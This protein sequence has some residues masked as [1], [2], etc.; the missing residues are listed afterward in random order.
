MSMVINSASIQMDFKP[1]TDSGYRIVNLH[2]IEYLGGRLAT[3]EMELW[4]DSSDDALKLVTEQQT[5]TIRIK[6][7][8]EDGIEYEIPVFI[9]SRKFY[10]L[11]LNITFVCLSDIAFTE[12][13]VSTE[14]DNIDD[15]LKTLY[16]GKQDIRT[17]TDIA[18]DLK[19]YQCCET[20]YELCTKL[21]YSF[22]NETIFAYSWE[23]LV[24][25][26][27]CG[28]SNSKGEME[29]LEKPGMK[30]SALT[31][32]EFTTP[33]TLNYNKY[34][35]YPP[36]NPWEDTDNSTTQ[37][38]YTE[39]EFLNCRAMNSY[40][41]YSIQGTDY[42]QLHQNYNYNRNLMDAGMYS[43][44]MIS[45]KDFPGYKIGDVIEFRS[46]EQNTK[47]PFT[48][49]LVATNEIY[50]ATEASNTLSPRGYAFEWTSTLY[51]LNKGDWG[52][53]LE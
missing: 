15:A 20:S 43:T 51:G 24:I 52:K 26:E 38:D 35:N 19:I 32:T 46:P 4:H 8:K 17:T 23:G 53:K 42:Y 1:W 18:N 29:N 14:F 45:S 11:K 41:Q 16:P 37:T 34:I 10:K 36:I 21:A 6:D 49:F 22:R 2:M 44:V 25:K 47:Y 50:Y 7:T 13:L 9:K 40:D 3:G 48:T 12:K 27:L 28:Q 31:I 39:Y 33:Y 30:V 5:G